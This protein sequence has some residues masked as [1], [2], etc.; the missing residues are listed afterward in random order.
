MILITS[1]NYVNFGLTSEFGHIPPC[2]LPVQ[3]KRLYEHQYALIEKLQTNL[4]SREKVYVSLPDDYE[5][6]LFDEIK[7][8]RLNI[9]VIK[10]SSK[11]SLLSSVKEA[12]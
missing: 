12:I 2:M 6:P 11:I 1:A 4:N 3:N 5:I 7:L 8:D 10:I 9:S